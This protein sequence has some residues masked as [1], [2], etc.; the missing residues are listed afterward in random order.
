LRAKTVSK[1]EP[2]TVTKVAAK[3]SK[4]N[5][6]VPKPSTTMATPCIAGIGAS[7]GGFKAIRSFLQA[8]PIDSG[9]AFVIVQHLDPKHN[10]LSAELFS[11]FTKM[12]VHEA[13][14]GVLVEANQVYTLPSD[15]EMTIKSGRLCLSQRR[16]DRPYLHLPIDHFFNS[17]GIDC[18]THAIGIILSGSGTDGALGLKT[19]AQHE[20]IVLVQNP[21]TAEFD[22]MPKSAIATGVSTHVL[23]VEQMPQVIADYARH[24]YATGPANAIEEEDD[25]NATK[26]LIDLIKA[27]H[28]YDFTGYK[29]GTFMRRIQRRMGLHG[30][31]KKSKY[32]TLLRKDKAEVDALF[33][34]LLIGVTEFF[35]DGEAWKTLNTTAIEHIIA[36]K[37]SDEPIRIWI[38]GCSTGEEAYTMA[39][40]VLDRLRQAR[41]NC[42]VQIF[43]TDT[44][45]EALEIARLATYPAGIAKRISPARLK[46]YFV[47]TPDLQHFVVNQDMR[48]TVVFGTQNLFADPPFGRVDLISCRNVLIYLE[49]EVQ[50]RV[51]NIFHFALRREGYLFLGSAESNSNRD[52]LF[53]PISKR[54]RI[55]QREGITRPTMVTLPTVASESRPGN[56][57]PSPA[58]QPS[59]NQVASIAQKLV[60]DRFAPASALINSHGDA[61]YF[62]GDTDEFLI[63]PRGAPTQN[64][65]AMVR[66]GLRAKLRA[67]LKES[68]G[69]LLPVEI[70]GVRMKRGNI[71]EPVKITIVPSPGAELG[72]L[73]LVVFKH[74]VQAENIPVNR[75]SENVL[76]RHLEEELQ[77]T[78]DDL[79]ATIE[80]YE[81]L[82][83]NLK[84][85][86]EEV[87]TTN[88]ELRSLNEELESSKEEL[89][90]LNEELS[91]VNQQL[92]T[93]VHEL[94]EA[95]SDINN[96]LISSDV[97]TI[98]LDQSLR[99]KWF[100][101][102]AKKQ[103]HFI[104][105]DIGRP[106]NDLL[107]AIE[108]DTL[109]GA[110]NEVL[111]KLT[112]VDHEFQVNNGRWYLRRILPYKTDTLQNDGIIITYTDITDVHLAIEARNESRKDLSDTIERT[113]KIRALSA[114]LAMAEER[115][116]RSLAK[117]LHDDLGQ[118]MAVIGLKATTIKKQKM[119]VPLREA[120]DDCVV[121]VDKAN[122]KLREMA[123]QLNPP[124]LDQLGLVTALEWMTDEVHRVYNL[125]VTIEDD[126][127]PKPMSP[128]VS[129]TMFRAVRE[130]LTNVSKHARIEKATITTERKPNDILVLTVSDAGAGFNQSA[131]S[132]ASNLDTLGLISMREKIGLLGG[133]VS[134][135]S[136]PGDGTTV[137]IEVPLL[138]ETESTVHA[139]SKPESKN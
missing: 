16:E 38:P 124:M 14:D 55:Y 101:P 31:F 47:A 74:D 11:K 129:A 92:E 128:A 46:R 61:L 77:A 133:T 18:G 50:K 114:A 52:D 64:L 25:P 113:D 35:R 53:K 110:T 49:A 51:L 135:K 100:A 12:Q 120:I 23:T 7:A 19:I 109:V 137:T 131:S 4:K 13:S 134:I 138:T 111:A 45:N 90:S 97:A 36:T 20:G 2:K 132:Q 75:G 94:E 121:V 44:N 27:Q 3:L 72:Q 123:L 117:Y 29:Q 24:P 10:S 79:L 21:T 87:V 105:S 81:A 82:T 139:K 57:V 6:K 63:R 95:N 102:A 96:L 76:V 37:A 126:G 106:I 28:G 78:R 8:M 70:S 73:F 84:N 107:S 98:C 119:S 67:A 103:F 43:A 115:E 58:S 127:K 68:T 48:S 66:E 40:V 108:D 59:F 34:D 62:C 93:K 26:N 91:T 122:N 104:A 17:L 15:K 88:E 32:V 136:N 69:S 42:P 39:M 86:N 83:E 112:V 60:L 1:P 118:I 130:L 85:S 9:V 5:I 89:Q 99:I 30:I 65:L 41:K 71:F 125:D 33:R 56:F 80:G 116:R 54:W 22:G